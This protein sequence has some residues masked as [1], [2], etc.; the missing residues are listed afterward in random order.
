MQIYL[1]N[2]S[3]T[4]LDHRVLEI[5]LPYFSEE[6]GNPESQHQKGKK[7]L[8]AIDNAREIIAE[9]LHCQPAEIIFCGSATETNNLAILG[10]GRANPKSHF[11]TSVIE[12]S[13][14]LKPFQQLEKEGHTVTYLKVDKEGL[15]HMEG[16]EKAIQKNT[17]LVSIMYANNEIGAIEPIAE[18]G[19][20]CRSRNIPFHMDACQAATTLDL[21]TKNLNADMMTLNGSKIYGPKGIG[22]LFVRQNIK[23]Q[24]IIYGG[25]QEK[26]LRSGTHNVPIIVG[27]AKALEL[28]QKEKNEERNRL[29]KLRNQSIDELLRQIPGSQINGSR[30]NRLAN[31]INI[32][33]PGVESTD[34]LLHL[35]EAGIYASAGSACSTGKAEP[36]YVLKA[37]GLPEEKIHSSIRLTLGKGTTDKDMEYVVEKIVKI[38]KRV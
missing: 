13:S 29:T 5:M 18:I 16:I 36:S 17:K 32:S 34:L 24:P 38:A 11:I 37:I 21:N 3:T 10:I 1:D 35:D 15:I 7:A 19:R 4:P 27:F 14:V 30:I 2:A 20:I 33:I 12:H 23:L 26:N 6:Y 9:I 22:I 25:G 8:L 28:A 31:N